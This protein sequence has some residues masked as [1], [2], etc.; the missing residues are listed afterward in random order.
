MD[1]SMTPT[2]ST[3]LPAALIGTTSMEPPQTHLI[4]C[5]CNKEKLQVAHAYFKLHFADHV[6]GDLHTPSR[7]IH[8][9]AFVPRG[10]HHV[11]SMVREGGLT[12]YAVFERDFQEFSVEEIDWCLR[13][14]QV[15]DVVRANRIALIS[16][17]GASSLFV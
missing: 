2:F 12:Y 8:A 14:W 7:L 10:E 16:G 1:Q 11:I 4:E 6:L 5:E 3:A 15:A 17:E 13:L 9:G